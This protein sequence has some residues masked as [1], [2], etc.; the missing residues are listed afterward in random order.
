MYSDPV[1]YFLTFTTYGTWLHGNE[2]SSVDKRHNQFGLPRLAMDGAIEQKER[3][4]LK[5][6]EYT[7]DERHR[8]VVLTTIREVDQF[9]GWY[10]WA[11]HVRSNHVH[12]VITANAKPEKVMIDLKAW[13]TRRLKESFPKSQVT[14]R[15]T[16][17]GSTRYLWKEADLSDVVRYVVEEQG[18]PMAVHA[19]LNPSLTLQA[20]IAE[21]QAK[22]EPEA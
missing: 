21:N 14:D 5:H 10:L 2:N 11:V 9:R 19:G 7:L 4:S 6:A 22:S 13:A 1:A 18:E 8:L 15:W 3:G 17:H 16:Q 20:L 12:V